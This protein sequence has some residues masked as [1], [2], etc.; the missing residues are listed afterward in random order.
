M[1]RVLAVDADNLGALINYTIVFGMASLQLHL[2]TLC[3]KLSYA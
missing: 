2:P 1:T 3:I